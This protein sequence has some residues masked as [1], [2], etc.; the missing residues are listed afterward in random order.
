M[1]NPVII[2][3]SRIE[4]FSFLAFELKNF[5]VKK[6]RLFINTSICKIFYQLFIF[7]SETTKIIPISTLKKLKGPDQK[8]MFEF[9]QNLIKKT[10]KNV[11]NIEFDDTILNNENFPKHIAIICDGNGRW[12][13]IRGMQRS[14][15]HIEG[16]KTIE[17]IVNF[18]QGIK[19]KYL[20]FYIFSTEN[21]KRP[22]QEVTVIMNLFK[23]Y[24]DKILRNF[25]KNNLK[26][27]FLGDVSA[28]SEEIQ[29]LI[30]EI[31]RI[32]NS[33][34]NVGLTVN[35]A[36]N[37]G[38][39]AEIV[40]AA[41]NLFRAIEKKDVVS[42]DIDEE[43]FS[44]FLYTQNQPDVDLLIRTGGEQRISNFLLWQS[45]YAEFVFDG[46]LWPDFSPDNLKLDIAKFL[47]RNR[48][49]GGI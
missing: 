39:R 33:K 16:A 2:D 5:F 48:R 3:F 20:T 10:K 27:N 13:K 24:L 40:N 1:I 23:Q 19:F 17:K 25:A 6:L 37:Y 8:N 41:K 31:Q 30:F 44:K 32:S 9:L 43:T 38:S 14:A 12:A 42:K 22:A 49:F 29:K 36:A 34:T 47:R 35:F 21:W 11:E 26:I 18:A 46:V 4:I 28:F 15:G 7:S 45:S